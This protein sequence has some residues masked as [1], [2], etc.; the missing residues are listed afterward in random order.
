MFAPPK[1]RFK[2]DLLDILALV[3]L[4]VAFYFLDFV[5]N[6]V[7]PPDKVFQLR[8]LMAIFYIGVVIFLIVIRRR[9]HGGETLLGSVFG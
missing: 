1:R 6:S 7:F 3:F 8:L 9:E 4:F 2:V 5:A